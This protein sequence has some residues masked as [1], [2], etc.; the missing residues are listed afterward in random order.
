MGMG[1]VY[2]NSHQYKKAEELFIKALSLKKSEKALENILF[3]YFRLEYIEGICSILDYFSREPDWSERNI[4]VQFM[5]AKYIDKNDYKICSLGMK[6][7]DYYMLDYYLAL[8]EKDEKEKEDLLSKV[9]KKNP[10]CIEAH[11]ELSKRYS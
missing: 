9:L 6:N 5:R 7:P 1:N 11:I 10:H 4:F 8:E 2:F 3:V